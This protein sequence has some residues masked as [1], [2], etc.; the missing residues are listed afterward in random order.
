M[1]FLPPK[2][3]QQIYVIFIMYSGVSSIKLLCVIKIF[4][5]QIF[6][7]SYCSHNLHLKQQLMNLPSKCLSQV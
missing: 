5:R 6:T 2:P 7:P 3:F 4:V 1:Q